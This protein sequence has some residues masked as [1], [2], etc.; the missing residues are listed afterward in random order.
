MHGCDEDYLNIIRHL[1]TENY[2][3]N[4]GIKDPS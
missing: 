1:K 3:S 4:K 2:S